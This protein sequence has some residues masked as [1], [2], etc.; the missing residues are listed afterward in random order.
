MTRRQRVERAWLDQT[1]HAYRETASFRTRAEDMDLNRIH[2][3]EPLPKAIG[4][5]KDHP[6]YALQ[7]HLLKF[8]GIYPPDAPTLGFIRGEP[9]YAR[10][11]VHTMHSREIWV[12]EARVVRPGQT[13]YK[14]VKARPKWDRVSWVIFFTSMDTH[15]N[16]HTKSI[17]EYFKYYKMNTLINIQ[18]IQKYTISGSLLQSNYKPTS[19]AQKRV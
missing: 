17:K 15:E 2:V 5:F 3:K 12:K 6:L 8:Q 18:K 7:R 4:E 11:C 13:A 10:D 14:V 16:F 9:I 1:L 19:N